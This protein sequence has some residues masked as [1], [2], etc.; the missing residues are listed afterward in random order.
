MRAL[1]K[2]LAR[3]L[4]AFA[5]TNAAILAVVGAV[6]AWTNPQPF[7]RL[8]DIIGYHFIAAM[9]SGFAAVVAQAY[10]DETETKGRNE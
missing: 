3:F 7:D 10:V 8:G 2:P 5:A 6:A 4:A 9:V 1:A